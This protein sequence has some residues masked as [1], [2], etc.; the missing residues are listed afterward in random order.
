M[1]YWPCCTCCYYVSYCYIG[2]VIAVGVALKEAA[3]AEFKAYQKQVVANAK[4]M[5]AA[6]QKRGYTIVSGKLNMIKYGYNI[7]LGK[8][9]Y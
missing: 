3:S 4:A 1:L 2:L 7:M 8:Y 9:Y 5:C 6:L